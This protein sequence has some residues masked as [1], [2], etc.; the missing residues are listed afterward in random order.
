MR[1]DEIKLDDS[2]VELMK[3]NRKRNGLTQEEISVL[4][5]ISSKKYS[6]IETR[7]LKSIDIRT[8]KKICQ[9]LD[10]EEK[11][12]INSTRTSLLLSNKM[13][14]DLRVLQESKGLTCKSDTIKYCIE[15]TLYSSHLDEIS[16]GL[17]D[18]IKEIISSTYNHQLNIL[19]RENEIYKLILNNFVN[20][21]DYE[22]EELKDTI[23]SIFY[24]YQ[25]I[26]K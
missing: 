3:T 18:E 24:K 4:L 23:N 17:L 10:I 20:G 25:H 5:M 14:K 16:V 7:K 11:D 9:I 12:L 19:V 21:N 13:E 1:K 22:I 8:Y 2:F 6:R 26:E 15:K